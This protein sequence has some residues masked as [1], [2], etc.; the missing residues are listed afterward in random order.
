MFKITVT[1]SRPNNTVAFFSRSTELN[2]LMTSLQ[3]AGKCLKETRSTS[4]NGLTFVY[5]SFWDSENDYNEYRALEIV[6]DY[7]SSKDTYNNTNQIISS[8]TKEHLP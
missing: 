7:N 2:T 5:E 8:V 3:L 4:N 6:S 1:S